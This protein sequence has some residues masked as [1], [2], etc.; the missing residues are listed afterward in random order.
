MAIVVCRS[1][2]YEISD[3]SSLKLQVIS[4]LC[5]TSRHFGGSVGQKMAARLSQTAPRTGLYT[6]DAGD[7]STVIGK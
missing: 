3:V 6:S 1:V 4:P 2:R 7:T 5:G